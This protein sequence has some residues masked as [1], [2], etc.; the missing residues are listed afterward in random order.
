MI[1]N[2]LGEMSQMKEK[3]RKDKNV[4]RQ[5]RKLQLKKEKKEPYKI[6]KT[7]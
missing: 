2:A 5:T 7:G 3:V 1:N 6:I 4:S